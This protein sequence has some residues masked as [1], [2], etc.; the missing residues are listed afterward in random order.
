M[1][2][3]SH[4]TLSRGAA[5]LVAVALLLMGA[6]VAYL[7]LSR[8][9]RDPS[10]STGVTS[11]APESPAAGADQGTPAAGAAQS[12]RTVSLT[13]EAVERAGI[14]VARAGSATIGGSLRLPGVV[15]PNGYRQVA[16]TPLAGGRVTRVSAELGTRVRQGQTMAEVYSP[17]LAEA[18][19]AYVSARAMLRA[20]DRELPRTERLAQIGSASRQELER[21]YAEHAAASA[22][23]QSAQSRLELL[24]VDPA[25]LE[26]LATGEQLTA[27]ISVP[28]PMSGVVTERTANVGLNV[29]PG[30][31]L[32]TVVDLSTVWIVADLYEHDFSRVRTGSEATVTT[33]AYPGLELQGRVDYIDPKVNAVTRTAQVRVEVPNPQGDLRLGMYADVAITGIDD[34]PRTT[35][36]M[37]AVQT[38]GDRTVVYVPDPG[39][40]GTFIERN[41]VLGR[42]TDTQAEVVAGLTPGDLVVT[43][44]SFYLRAER[45][46]LGPGPAAT[47]QKGVIVVQ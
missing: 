39:Q 45:D 17:E 16:V 44:G 26:T 38:I 7:L 28:A 35:V 43:E 10:P 6:A 34:S 9:G 12:P 5:G 2:S 27:T 13:P 29:D 11:G 18:Q 41:V 15:Q 36:A 1:T 3:Q 4:V 22:A 40:P 8:A 42:A 14:V 37:T 25:T 23:V 30:M 33:L 32:F 19:T 21:I 24:G 31:P 46:R 47:V 20:H